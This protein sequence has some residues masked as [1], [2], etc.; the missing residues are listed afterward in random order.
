ML[1]RCCVAE[2]H[3]RSGVGISFSGLAGAEQGLLVTVAIALHNIPEGLAVARAMLQSYAVFRGAAEQLVYLLGLHCA[4][5]RRSG[6]RSTRGERSVRDWVGS[7]LFYGPTTGRN[8]CVPIRRTFCSS[9]AIRI[10]VR[11]RVDD[12]CVL[13]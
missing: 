3:F 11:G 4:E 8:T 12:F 5:C 9:A 1:L 7:T 13:P 2:C 6:A 10:W